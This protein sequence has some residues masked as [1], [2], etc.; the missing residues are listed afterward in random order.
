MRRLLHI[1]TIHFRLF[2]AKPPHAVHTGSLPLAPFSAPPCKLRGSGRPVG[3]A[4]RV[5]SNK[6]S[7]PLP[8]KLNNIVARDVG[9][10]AV[11]NAAV[12]SPRQQSHSQ[13][14][15]HAEGPDN[16]QAAGALGAPLAGAEQSPVSTVDR[17]L[18]APGPPPAAEHRRRNR[19]VPEA[20][21]TRGLSHDLQEQ[22]LMEPDMQVST[23][24][25]APLWYVHVPCP[26]GTAVA[27]HA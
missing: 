16:T 25:V 6:G 9:M 2:Q 5:F 26:L 4:P 20:L 3:W 11:P 19:N 22:L 13:A 7:P 27:L 12:A 1:L 8:E 24:Q 15:S 21:Q 23:T 10:G 18:A 17:A 14:G